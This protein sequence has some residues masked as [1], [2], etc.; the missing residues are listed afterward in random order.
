VP[1][2]PHTHFDF[3]S[4]QASGWSEDVVSGV[5]LD[6]SHMFLESKTTEIVCAM[7][8]EGSHRH[9][10]MRAWIRS[11]AS[12]GGVCEGQI[13]AGIGFLAKNILYNKNQQTH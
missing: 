6:F 3:F 1:L 11:L 7:A 9:P 5:C 12:P 13:G 2:S 10:N 4:T 8:Q